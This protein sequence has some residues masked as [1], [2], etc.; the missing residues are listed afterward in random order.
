MPSESKS[1]TVIL[2][3]LLNQPFRYVSFTELLIQHALFIYL[4]IFQAI[5][6]G[7]HCGAM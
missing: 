4:C 6:T 1:Y 2:L 7:T 3:V 5:P